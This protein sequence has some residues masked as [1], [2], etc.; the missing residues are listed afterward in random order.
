MNKEVFNPD[1]SLSL[2]DL[3][4]IEDFAKAF[5]Y[6]DTPTINKILYCNGMEVSRGYTTETKQHRN[7]QGKV[8]TCV[9]YEGVERID[10]EWLRT[11]AA[12]MEAYVASSDPEVRKDMKNMSKQSKSVRVDN[13]ENKECDNDAVFE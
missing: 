11:G 1:Y 2:S 5:G 4:L 3:L 13:T 12:S 8:V 7:L 9:R 6:N 10:K